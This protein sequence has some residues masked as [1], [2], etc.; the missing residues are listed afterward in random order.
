MLNCDFA[1]LDQLPT[2]ALELLILEH[3]Q[4]L[5]AF[6][7]HLQRLHRHETPAAPILR[8]IQD[9]QTRLSDLEAEAARRGVQ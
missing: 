6:E 8:V 2:G 4:R 7:A 9:T 3:R 5:A 1:H